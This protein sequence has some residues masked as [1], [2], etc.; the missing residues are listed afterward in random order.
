MYN[1]DQYS[2]STRSYANSGDSDR[3]SGSTG[4]QSFT[5]GWDYNGRMTTGPNNL[6]VTRNWDNATW[7]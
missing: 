4:V 3:L 2:T 6:G 1:D 5:L 7:Q